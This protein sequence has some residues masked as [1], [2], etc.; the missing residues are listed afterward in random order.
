MHINAI[1]TL[2]VRFAEE[3]DDSFEQRLAVYRERFE[4]EQGCV[5]FSVSRSQLEP[6]LWLLTGHWANAAQMTEHFH[7]EGMTELVRE[8]VEYQAS[9]NFASFSKVITED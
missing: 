1:N 6:H 7:T 3:P 8:L 2:E 5:G 9:V 4:A